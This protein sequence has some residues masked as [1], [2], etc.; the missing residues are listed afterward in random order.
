MTAHV[1]PECP[2]CQQHTIVQLGDQD[3]GCLSCGFSRSFMAQSYPE[4]ESQGQTTSRI[5][6][7]DAWFPLLWTFFLAIVVAVFLTGSFQIRINPSV[8]DLNHT[9][10]EKTP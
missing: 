4:M 8:A 5:T 10:Q 1:N 7:R 6:Y 9:S 3:W 2:N